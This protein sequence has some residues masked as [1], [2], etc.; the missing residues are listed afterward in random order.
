MRTLG[1]RKVLF[2]TNFPQMPL[3]RCVREVHDLDLPVETRRDFVRENAR[4]VFGL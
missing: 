3:E 4:R 1:R 2:G